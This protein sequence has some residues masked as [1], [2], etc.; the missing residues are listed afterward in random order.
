MADINLYAEVLQNIGQITLYASFQTDKN[1]GTTVD[2]SSDR[3]F[4]S[5][6]HDGTTAQLLLPLAVSGT[7]QVTIPAERAKD[8]SLRLALEDTNA[9]TTRFEDLGSEEPWSAAKFTPSGRLRCLN[10]ERPVTRSDAI[11][12]WKDL[13]SENWAEM[14]DFWHCHRPHDEDKPSTGNENEAAQAKGYG[15]ANRVRATKGTAFVDV[16]SFLLSKEDCIDLKV[17]ALLLFDLYFLLHTVDIKKAAK[18]VAFRR[19]YNALATDTDVL[20]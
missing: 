9:V 14:M 4:I 7:A 16:S 18:A 8:V 2:I 12:T 11:F 13:P 17:S 1:E 3:R 6:T 5:V 10:C 19:L 20:E 15:A